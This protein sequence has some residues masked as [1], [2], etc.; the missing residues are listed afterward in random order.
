MTDLEVPGPIDFVLI[1][2]PGE[3]VGDEM[4]AALLDLVDSGTIRL[5]DL[6]VIR[7]DDAGNVASVELSSLGEAIAGFAG[8]RSGL[9][10]DDDVAE[11][12]AAMEPNT[13]ALLLVYE[14][15]WAIPFATAALSQGGQVIATQRL[16]V[17]DIIDALDA[18]DAAN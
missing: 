3:A 5:Y 14:N 15:A 1:E 4:A 18:A 12:G 7:K 17:Q 9:L 13:A 2:F 16:G 6:T 11:A 8:A 10:S